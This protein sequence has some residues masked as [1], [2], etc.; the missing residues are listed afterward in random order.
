[1]RLVMQPVPVPKEVMDASSMEAFKVRLAGAL[2]NL[3]QSL[4]MV[5]EWN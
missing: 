3:L 5:G 1:M 4:P 2:S